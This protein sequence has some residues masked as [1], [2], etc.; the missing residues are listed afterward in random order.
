MAITKK[1][2]KLGKNKIA[3]IA[4]I[5]GYLEEKGKT[6]DW[7]LEEIKRKHIVLGVSPTA[8]SFEILK[9]CSDSFVSHISEL[10]KDDFIVEDVK[11][12]TKTFHWFFTDIVG[13]SDPTIPVKIQARKINLLN[14]LMKKRR[15][16]N[17]EIPTTPMFKQLEME[18]P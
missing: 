7:L 3:L 8:N 12:T 15:R 6:K 17:K 14:A 18:W 13:S 5:L 10:L 1:Q 11:T 16:L 4:E 9:S 2:K